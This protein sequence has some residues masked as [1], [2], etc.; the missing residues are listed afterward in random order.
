MAAELKREAERNIEIGLIGGSL[1]RGFESDSAT[2]MLTDAEGTSMVDD[3]GCICK[4]DTAPT[5]SRIAL[6]LM[7]AFQFC[8]K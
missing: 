2:G 6:E 4:A 7:E 5:K 8:Q 1:M 3:D